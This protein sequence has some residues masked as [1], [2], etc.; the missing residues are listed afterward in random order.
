MTITL[1]CSI[2]FQG[3]VKFIAHLGN[4]LLITFL[5]PPDEGRQART[6]LNLSILNIYPYPIVAGCVFL[7]INFKDFSP[8]FKWTN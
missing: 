8:F 1:A 2:F 3:L 4:S 5:L 7:Q 6:T